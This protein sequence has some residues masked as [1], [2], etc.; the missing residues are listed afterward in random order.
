MDDNAFNQF[1]INYLMRHPSSGARDVYKLIYQKN[2]GI[3]HLLKD[4]D[5]AK[6][7]FL[8]EF[9]N[10]EG[11]SGNVFEAIDPAKRIFRTHIGPYKLRGG[12]VDE[13]WRA[14]VITGELITPNKVAFREE[15]ALASGILRA[16]EG[17][18]VKELAE[19][20]AMASSDKPP[21]VHHSE[22]HVL[23]EK[24]S[25]R[26]VSREAIEKIGG[27]LTEIFAEDIAVSCEES[28]MPDVQYHAPEHP[29]DI[30][31][32]GIRDLA[33]PIVVLDKH[34]ERQQTVAQVTMSVDLPARWRGTHMSRFIEVLNK[35][36]GE[37]T[38]IQIRAILEEMLRIFA[39]R[40]AH[41]ILVFPYF[42][43]KEAPVS[44]TSSI[45]KYVASFDGELDEKGY[46]FRLGVRVP[47]TTL[48]PCS[49]ELAEKGAH[50]QRTYVEI[51]ILSA[52]FVWL[53]ELIEIAEKAASSPVYSL[54]KRGDEKYVTK[55]AYENPRFVEDVVRAIAKRLS[56]KFDLA[57]FE[58]TAESYESIHNHNAFAKITGGRGDVVFTEYI[59]GLVAD[60]DD[61][62]VF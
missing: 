36:R 10:V 23:A 60:A 21:P 28:P 44:R 39:A 29:I 25:Y 41:I 38:H 45:V 32:V 8:K 17:A 51:T 26:I 15:W 56:D 9:E 54:L 7:A 50:S 40:A 33:Y 61:F 30:D 6:G 34:D 52:K 53:E 43:E 55:R 12:S 46:R 19:L 3:S 31:R 24:P 16:L 58:V 20:D 48:C 1:V 47:I 57:E 49:K 27:E 22:V 11:C 35:F 5:I 18:N 62:M 2:M 14:V 4:L 59:S 13:L 42:I 37:I